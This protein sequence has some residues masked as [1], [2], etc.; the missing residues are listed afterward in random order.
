MTPTII[1]VRHGAT[2]FDSGPVSR[3]RGWLDV[4]LNDAG[5]AQAVAVAEKLAADKT[6]IAR[7]VSSDLT[8]SRETAD[9]IV[10]KN[11]QPPLTITRGLRPWDLGD[12]TARTVD[13]SMPEML[14]LLDHEE[15]LPSSGGEPF[16][17]FQTRALETIIP[18][19]EEAKEHPERGA[20]VVVSH[21]RVARL[22][23]GWCLVGCP[24]DGTIDMQPLVDT[25]DVV[26][27]GRDVVMTWNGKS[28]DFGSNDEGARRPD[29][30]AQK[31]SS[32]HT[33]DPFE[34]AVYEMMGL[35]YGGLA[36]G[37]ANVAATGIQQ[38][39]Q[40][41]A[42]N[43]VKADSAAA[44]QRSISADAAWASAEAM[45]EV[46]TKSDPSAVAADTVSRDLAR[47]DANKAAAALQSDGIAKRCSAAQDS[48]RSA[49]IVASRSPK[50]PT[51][52]ARF[53]AWQTIANAC[54]G[55]VSGG[56]SDAGTDTGDGHKGK[57]MEETEGGESW[58]VAKHAGLPGWG[59]IGVGVG[60]TGLLGYFLF[61][62]R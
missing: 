19:A 45:L 8:R 40:E 24:E 47:G 32:M 20:I 61:R 18:L 54:G 21:S 62:H 17:T 9:Q 27:V 58:I 41:A 52:Q 4:P 30:D 23:K 14:R 28:W 26:P 15:E 56:S 42:Q 31:E 48:L 46:A 34:H 16:L 36:Q 13:E 55:G 22:L 38:Q 25:D 50:D 33:R 49:A 51:A 57:K 1:F 3:V 5:Q 6:P 39:Q 10:E 12:M 11:G 2:D 37:L 44:V 43:K 59:W 53:H 35:D 7:V 29:E 60:V